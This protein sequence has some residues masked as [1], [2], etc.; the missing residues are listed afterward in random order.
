M[1]MNFQDKAKVTSKNNLFKSTQCVLKLCSYLNA[2]AAE[3]H[4][5]TQGLAPQLFSIET[6]ISP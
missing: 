1:D 6:S 2:P 3:H 5:K 4:Q